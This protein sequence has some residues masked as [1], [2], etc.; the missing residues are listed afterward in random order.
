MGTLCRPGSGLCGLN[1]AIA[2]RGVGNK[3]TEQ[4]ARRVGDL[5]DR[6][7]EGK[8]IRLRGPRETAQLSYELERGRPDLVVR[9]GWLEVMQGLDAATH[10]ASHP[11]SVDDK[12]ENSASSAI[13]QVQ[14]EVV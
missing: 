5:I 3:R 4:F 6:A 13:N 12:P 14:D 1:L 11:L 10:A 2:W 9:G 7:V 8:P